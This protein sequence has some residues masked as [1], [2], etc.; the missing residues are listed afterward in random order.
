MT[1]QRND[2]EVRK[3]SNKKTICPNCNH[4]NKKE[5][6]FCVNCG[7]KLR[8]SCKCWVT[9]QDNYSC[10][11]KSC[12]G[13]KLLT[14]LTEK[15]IHCMAR[16]IQSS[17]FAEGW[18]FCGCQ[19]CKYWKD[20]CEKTFEEENGRIHYDVIMKKLQQITGLDMSLNASNLKEK[21]QRDFTKQEVRKV[22]TNVFE[23][24]K[25]I[26]LE[27]EVCYQSL[28]KE[29]NTYKELEEVIKDIA[30]LG[31]YD[32]FG[33]TRNFLVNLMRKKM[34]EEKNNLSIH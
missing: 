8:E 26:N 7:Q 17:V 1:S 20:G 6:N 34:E 11:E 13:Y 9:K 24:I 4:E 27:V 30:W 32:G 12:P 21:F 33:M 22:S 16:I 29:C 10:A 18:I 25:K 5:A 3:I 14:Q 28:K 31:N 2:R 23:T 19:Y 15:D